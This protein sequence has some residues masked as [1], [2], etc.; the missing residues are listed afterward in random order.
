MC[1]M[2]MFCAVIYGVFR[3]PEVSEALRIIALYTYEHEQE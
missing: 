1:E 2:H 3:A